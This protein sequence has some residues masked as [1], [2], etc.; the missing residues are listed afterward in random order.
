VITVFTIGYD[1]DGVKE[2]TEISSLV[3]LIL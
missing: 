2:E 1:E 3:E